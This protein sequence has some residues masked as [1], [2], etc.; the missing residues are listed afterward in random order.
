MY[1]YR[2]IL[3]RFLGNLKDD[4]YFVFEIGY[5]QAEDIRELALSYDL[6]ADVYKDYGGNDRVAIIKKR[7]TATGKNTPF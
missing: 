7:L 5:D 3:N 1:F 4:G 2:L 6:K